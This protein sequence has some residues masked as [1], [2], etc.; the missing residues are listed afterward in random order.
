LLFQHLWYGGFNIKVLNSIE[1]ELL[2]IKLSAREIDRA[3]RQDMNLDS[4]QDYE[5]EML[6]ALEIDMEQENNLNPNN[7]NKQLLPV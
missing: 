1:L 6:K 3:L 7:S 2:R 4:L 5:L